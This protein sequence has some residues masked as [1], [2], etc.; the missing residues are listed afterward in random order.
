VASGRRHL[1]RPLG[2]GLAPDLGEIDRVGGARLHQSLDVDLG[3]RQTGASG[4]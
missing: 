1:E 4:Q 2:G 3:G